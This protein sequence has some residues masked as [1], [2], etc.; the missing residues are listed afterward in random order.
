[1]KDRID[2]LLEKYFEGHSSLEEEKELRDLLQKAEGFETEKQF[3]LGLKKISEVESYI[4][5]LPKPSRNIYSFWVKIAATLLV[6][7]IA[8]IAVFQFQ[9]KQK[10]QEAYHQVMQAFALIQ[11]NMHKGLNSMEAM[12]DFRHLN[13]T[14]ELFELNTK[15]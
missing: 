9:E 15:K 4:T 6:F 11:T 5:A 1:M 12:E 14:E 8:G 3:F 7:L 2:I 13:T 10:G